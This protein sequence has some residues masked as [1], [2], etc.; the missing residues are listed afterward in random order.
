[1]ATHLNFVPKLKC[2]ELYS[3][4][5]ISNQDVHRSLNFTLRQNVHTQHNIT[6]EVKSCEVDCKVKINV[7][8]IFRIIN[9]T[10]KRGAGDN[11]APLILWYFVLYTYKYYFDR[12]I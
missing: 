10:T 11:S 9:T 2:V 3:K 1:M 7:F 4:Y 6:D 8:S 5:S 12:K